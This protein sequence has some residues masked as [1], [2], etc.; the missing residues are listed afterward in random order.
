MGASSRGE[1][2][3]GALEAI[4]LIRCSAATSK[5]YRI[6]IL[7]INSYFFFCIPIE[8]HKSSNGQS[9]MP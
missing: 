4:L 1:L 8:H 3:E 2:F 7:L 5:I 6:Y 9:Y